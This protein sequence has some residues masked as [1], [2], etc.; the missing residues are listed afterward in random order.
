MDDEVNVSEADAQELGEH[1]LGEGSNASA[2]TWSV[3]LRSGGYGVTRRAIVKGR[4][5][6]EIYLFFQ[7][8]EAAGCGERVRAH[9]HMLAMVFEHPKG[10]TTAQCSSTAARI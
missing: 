7:D 10:R 9:R 5:D 3:P 8:L 1:R 6:D 2:S 4:Q